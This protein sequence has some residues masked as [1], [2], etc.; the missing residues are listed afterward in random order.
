MLHTIIR[1]DLRIAHTLCARHNI[2]SRVPKRPIHRKV[3]FRVYFGE[4]TGNCDMAGGGQV[5]NATGSATCSIRT[6]ELNS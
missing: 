3:E 5:G 4:I 1:D 6:P 2:V